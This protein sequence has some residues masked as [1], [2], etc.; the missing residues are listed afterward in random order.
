MSFIISS[1]FIEVLGD[2]DVDLEMPNFFGTIW[3]KLVK[4]SSRA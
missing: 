3:R 2:E 1:Y 4:P